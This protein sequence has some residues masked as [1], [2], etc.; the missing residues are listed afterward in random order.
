MLR[1]RKIS[2]I[3]LKSNLPVGKRCA[4]AISSPKLLFKK[5]SNFLP[6]SDAKEKSSPNYNLHD[7]SEMNT[8][9]F[10]TILRLSVRVSSS[11]LILS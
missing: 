4:F 1:V 10:V 5:E 2:G 9:S 3:I 11:I 8:I 7:M 6:F